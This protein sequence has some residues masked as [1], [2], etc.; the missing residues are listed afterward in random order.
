VRVNGDCGLDCSAVHGL[1]VGV[2]FI[3]GVS[4]CGSVIEYYTR[5][6]K[7]V[8]TEDGIGRN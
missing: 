4:M 6:C 8:T 3:V 1:V 2:A 7:E 5:I